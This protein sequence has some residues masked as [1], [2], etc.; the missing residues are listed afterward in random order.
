MRLGMLP[1]RRHAAHAQELRRVKQ[2]FIVAVNRQ[3]PASGW[4]FHV[5]EEVKGERELT[6]FVVMQKGRALGFAS[7][8]QRINKEVTIQKI[9]IELGLWASCCLPRSV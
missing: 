2:F 6:M 1:F 7:E 4:R 8:Q 3:G 9:T 5:S